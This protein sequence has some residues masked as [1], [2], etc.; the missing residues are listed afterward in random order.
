MIVGLNYQT[1]HARIFWAVTS[2]VN[3]SE[4]RTCTAVSIGI[5]L[6]VGVPVHSGR[7]WSSFNSFNLFTAASCLGVHRSATLFSLPLRR[8]GHRHHR[9]ALHRAQVWRAEPQRAMLCAFLRGEAGLGHKRREYLNVLGADKIQLSRVILFKST[10][11][12]TLASQENHE[13]CG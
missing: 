6:R 7:V 1:G 5:I 2:N 9:G 11:R 4:Y 3:G 13:G 8:S 12:P 10:S